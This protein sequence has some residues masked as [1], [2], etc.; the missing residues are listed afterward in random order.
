M[1]V[2]KKVTKEKHTPRHRPFGVPCGARQSGPALKLGPQKAR[3]SDIRA[4]LPPLRLRSSAAPKG[5]KIKS[6]SVALHC[7]VLL[8]TYHPVGDAEKRSVNGRGPGPMSEAR[9]AEFR[10]RLIGA[11]IA[12]QSRSDR[13]LRVAF[14]WFLLLAKRS[15]RRDSL[16]AGE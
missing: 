14:S 16:P 3:A 13:H 4:G 5:P 7:L 8:L 10:S 1:L 12:G 15:K 11:S 9:R 2:Q 6:Q